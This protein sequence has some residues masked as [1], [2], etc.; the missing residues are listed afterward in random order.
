MFHV[1]SMNELKS[2]A[3]AL[4]FGLLLAA[5]VCAQTEDKTPGEPGKSQEKSAAEQTPEIQETVRMSEKVARLFGEKSY[6]QALELA[7]RVVEIRE[8]ALA[9]DDKL[10]IEALSNLAELYLAKN[11][12]KEAEPVFQKLLAHYDK[13]DAAEPQKTAKALE[14][15]A[16]LSYRKKKYDEAETRLLR[17]FEIY[18]KAPESDWKQLASLKLQLAELYSDKGDNEKAEAAYLRA[19]ELSDMVK[20]PPDSKKETMSSNAIERYLCFL[21]QTR[22][23]EEASRI[24]HSFTE[25]RMAEM[26]SKAV[27]ASEGN[28]VQGGVLNGRAISMPRPE[29][30]S[31][32][33]GVQG[34]VR[35]HIMINERGEVVEAKATCG[36]MALRQSAERAALKARFTPTLLSGAP[37][38]VSGIIKYNFWLPGKR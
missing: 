27:K 35:V 19:I 38:K 4:I 12:Y 14:R 5:S 17:A 16:Y 23:P 6:D 20:E 24:E 3:F 15:L 11:M 7:K 1:R 21:S 26:L 37:V 30:P 2:L 28:G 8:K 9:P 13:P 10:V 34:T 22:P 18:E 31:P 36:P 33:K 29:Y 25:K 32:S